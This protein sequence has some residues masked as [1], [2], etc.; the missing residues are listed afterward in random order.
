MGL[1]PRGLSVLERLCSNAAAGHQRIVVHV[2]DPHLEVGGRVWRTSQ[3]GEL[4]MNTVASQVTMFT[5]DSVSCDGPV[6]TG[7]S[8]FEWA[9]LFV[10]TEPF[11]PYPDWVYAE[12]EALGPDSYPTRAFYGHYLR[13]VL[14][15]LERFVPDLVVVRR[16][17]TAAVG[18]ADESSGRQRVALADGTA[19]GGLDAVVLALGHLDQRACAD[20]TA[21]TEHARRHDLVYVPTGNPAEARLDRIRPGM[22]VGL[23]GLGLNYFDYQAL[24]TVGRD[25]RFVRDEGGALRYEPSGLEPLL[26]AGSRRGVPYHSR[27]ANQKGVNGRHQPLFLT[28]EVIKELRARAE[29]AKED[30]AGVVRFVADVWPL[31]DREVRAVYHHALLVRRSGLTTATD[32]LGEYV[33]LPDVADEDAL[34][35]RFGIAAEDRWDWERIARPAGTRRFSGPADYQAWLL[36]HLRHD[37]DEARQGNVRGPLKAALDVMRDIRNE[38]RLVVDHGGLAGSS[39]RDELEGWYT[40]LNAYLSIGPPPS[41]VE[42]MVALMEA[43]VLRIC[44]PGMRVAAAPGGA[45]WLVSSDVPGDEVLVTALVDARLHDVD[46]R[47]TTD[48]LV[49][50]LLARG[51]CTTYRISDPD[52]D[53]RTGGLA[54]TPKPYRLLDAAGRAHPRRFAFGVPTEPVHWGTAA[55]VRPGV[56]S[57]ILGD[58]DAIARAALSLVRTTEGAQA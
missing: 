56:D 21:Y 8:L 7:P 38:V 3:P 14:G 53:Y 13:W 5:D 55:G 34:L 37:L 28:A 19:L 47:C 36:D 46:I 20:E 23:R 54:V 50:G 24:L 18:L 15:R 51:E 17:A 6:R 49:S 22:P 32:F 9:K 4:L 48:P 42:E 40:P 57:V 2:V 10:P 29:A 43:G 1:G 45:G 30:G 26:V 27:G 12:A 16:H 58:A 33:G 41:R 25:G 44:G 39:Y 52:D 11:G 35:T 31:V